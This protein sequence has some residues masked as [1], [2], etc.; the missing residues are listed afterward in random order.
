MSYNVIGLTNPI[1]LNDLNFHNI[2]NL[3]CQ[4]GFWHV[5]STIQLQYVVPSGAP[6]VDV[7]A[8]IRDGSTG[9]TWASAK[10]SLKGSYSGEIIYEQL[11]L[12]AGLNLTVPGMP[13]VVD[14]KA[15]GSNC[16]TVLASVDGFV[17]PTSIMYSQCCTSCT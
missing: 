4:H 9:V 3:S 5:T 17:T 1:L 8:R 10:I 15:N 13:W 14:I 11:S 2:W 7:V 6:K 12:N 16:V